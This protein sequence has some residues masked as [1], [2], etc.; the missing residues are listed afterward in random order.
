MVIKML[1]NIPGK[2]DNEMDQLT[3]LKLIK[4]HDLPEVVNVIV[5]FSLTFVSRR[6]TVANDALE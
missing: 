2:D 3:N 1:C 5:A 4:S 6:S